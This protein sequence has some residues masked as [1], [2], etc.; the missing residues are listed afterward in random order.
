MFLFNINRGMSDIRAGL[1]HHHIWMLL[2]W[3]EIKQR[4]NRSKIG[5][6]WLTISMGVMVAALGVIYGA[7]FKMNLR[8][9]LPMLAIGLVIWS[10]ISLTIT[11]GCNTYIASTNYLK[12]ISL[13]RS[14]FILQT[15]WRNLIVLAHNFVIVVLVLI[16]F[17]I[18][19]WHTLHLFVL[20][21]LLLLWN[22]WWICTVASLVC[23]R[24]RDVPQIVISILQVIFYVTPILFKKDM[25][26]KYPWIIDFNPFA[27]LIE[28]IR[29]PLL[30]E[31]PSIENWIVCLV[32][33]VAGTVLA[34]FMHGRYRAR[35]P[36]W[37]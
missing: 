9:Y 3:L 5:P 29:S 7:L 11:D 6:F 13:P 8:D 31:Y 28:I 14:I 24:F 34:I 21:M 37:V 33:A 23:A 32:M 18:S 17:Q 4:Y 20:G 27:H 2:A 19:F 25:L 16:G 35:V 10:F 12:Q 1:Q 26:D 22:L 30:G 36:F 15:I